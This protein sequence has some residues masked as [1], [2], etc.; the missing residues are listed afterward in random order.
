MWHGSRCRRHRLNDGDLVTVQPGTP[1]AGTDTITITVPAG[2]EPRIFGRL[3]VTL[4]TAP[5]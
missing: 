2:P 5:F 3:K 1:Q 4:S